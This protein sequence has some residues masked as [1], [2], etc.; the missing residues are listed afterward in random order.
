MDFQLFVISL[1][2]MHEVAEMSCC[3]GFVAWWLLVLGFGLFVG[4]IMRRLSFLVYESRF[5]IPSSTACHSSSSLK[6]VL[7]CL[8]TMQLLSPCFFM[9]F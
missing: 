4:S 7:Y 1:V 9:P 6:D 5:P 8:K 3:R 2:T